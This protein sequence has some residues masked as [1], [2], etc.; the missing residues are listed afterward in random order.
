MTLKQRFER[1]VPR[2]TLEALPDLNFN[3]KGH[4]TNFSLPLETILEILDVAVGIKKRP[5]EIADRGEVSFRQ[6]FPAQYLGSDGHRV[7]SRAELLIDNWLYTQRPSI[8]H[9][10]ERRLPVVEEAYCDFYVPL[11]DCYIEYWG[12]GTPEYKNRRR[13]KE[14]IYAAHGFDMISLEDQDI[15]ELDDRLP[16]KLLEFFPDGFEFQ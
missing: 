11:G 7:R 3:A 12:L 15:A 9:A 5:G 13:R 10:Y 4:L 16:R 6:K 8:G 14:G 2:R 1:P